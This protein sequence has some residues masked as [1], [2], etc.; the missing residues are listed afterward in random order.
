MNQTAAVNT[1]QPIKYHKII[2]DRAF[3]SQSANPISHQ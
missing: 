3:V 2:T 1:I